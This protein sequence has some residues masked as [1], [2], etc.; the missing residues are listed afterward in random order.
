MAFH[1]VIATIGPEQK[2]RVLFADLT[3]EQLAE[4]FVRPYEQGKSFFSGHELIS[5]HDLRSIHI[6]RTQRPDRT[7]RDEIC[8]KEREQIDR[9]NAS[10]SDLVM[11]S[12]G[13]GNEPGDITAAGEDI[14]HTVIKGPPGFNANRGQVAASVFK[15]TVGIVAAVIGSV[16]AAGI[17]ARLNWR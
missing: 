15:W 8:R 10:G 3:S 11:I 16:V 4:R 12:V 13:T 1:H 9:L 6:I 17:L 14:T 5:P 7:E 2:L